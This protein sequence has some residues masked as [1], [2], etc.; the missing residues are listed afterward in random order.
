M[1]M[2]K[3]CKLCRNFN[4]LFRPFSCDLW[5]ERRL[6][7]MKTTDVNKVKACNQFIHEYDVISIYNRDKLW[8]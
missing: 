8:K 4:M 6:K 7:E 2:T 3:K 5:I 1:D